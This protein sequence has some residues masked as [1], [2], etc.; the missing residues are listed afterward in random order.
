[1][2][3][4]REYGNASMEGFSRS[5]FLDSANLDFGCRKPAN[6]EFPESDLASDI[7]GPFPK[8]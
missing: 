8:P 1:M 5:A 2:N 7:Q 4:Q 6:P 3:C